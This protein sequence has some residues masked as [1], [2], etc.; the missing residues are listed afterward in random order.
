MA[1]VAFTVAALGASGVSAAAAAT[2]TGSTAATKPVAGSSAKRAA[3]PAAKA[4][5]QKAAAPKAAAPKVRP[6]AFSLPEQPGLAG[7]FVAAGPTRLLDTRKGIGTGGVVAPVGQVPLLLDV[8]QVAGGS[9]TPTSVVLNVTVTN[10]TSGGYVVVYPGSSSR[11]ASSNLDYAAGQTV[12]N[13]VT[14]P[15]GYD[16]KVQF[17]VSGGHADVIADLFGYYTIDKAASTYVP[18]GPSRILDTRS[19]IGTGGVKAPVG[20]G[21]SIRLQ[22]DGV[23]GIPAANVSAVVLNVTETNSSTGGY[24][25]AY[26]DGGSVPTTSNLD[27]PAGKTV[28]NLVTVP[29]GADGKIDFFNKSGTVD[30]IADLAGYYLANAP[31][32]GGILQNLDTPTRLLD[33]R[34]G[35]G[36]GGV[37]APVGAGASISLQVDG[38]AGIA[39][40]NVTA[41]ILNVTE[42]TPSVGGYLTVYPDGGSVPTASNIDF[43]AGETVP[44][45]VVVPVGAD[46]KVDF[47]NKYG[48]TNVIADVFGYFQAGGDLSV[49]TP[50]FTSPTVDTTSGAVAD[51]VTWTVTDSNP[52]ATQTGGELVLR[53]QGSTPNTFVGQWYV[54]DFLSTQ[55]LYQ[56]ATVVSGDAAKATF[57]YDFAVPQYAGAAT[58]K[59]VVALVTVFENATQ[60][61]QLLS[62]S[63]LAGAGNA[64]TATQQVSTVAPSYDLLQL[65]NNGNPPYYYNAGNSEVPYQLEVQDGQSGFWQGTLTISG[66]GGKQ[67]SGSFYYQNDYGVSS[68]MCQGY[69]STANQ[70]TDAHCY[71]YVDIPAGAPAGTWTVSSISLTNN[72]G[73]TKTYTGISALP[74]SVTSDGVISASNFSPSAT[75]LNNWT[76]NAP[77][78]LSMRIAGAQSGVASIQLFW[79][80]FLNVCAQQSTT[81]TAGSGG[82]YTIPV[83][84]YR[85][86]Q[87]LS[88]CTLDGVVITDGAGNVS[89]YGT[90]FGAAATGVKVTTMP[91]TTPPTAS[92]ASLNHTTIAQSQIGNFSYVINVQSSDPTAPV[93]SFS[94]Y[95]YD[96]TGNVVGQEFGGV[97]AGPDGALML[98][99]DVPYGLAVGTYTVGFT[100]TDEAGL[101]T[102][103]GEPGSA[104]VP[105]GPLTFTVTAG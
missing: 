6:H 43:A 80:P 59:W 73:Q 74:I 25:T 30:V 66:P 29:V 51:T 16:G 22:V 56:G 85:T 76:S 26:P 32:S 19:G 103:Y 47:F 97:S 40:K 86:Y 104:P 31:R 95:L 79:G 13:M 69:G 64:V 2:S 44:N 83:V 75:Q 54:V 3:T 36:T 24:L 89:L 78:Q 61:G 65:A 41:V 96:S 53:Q 93:S 4:A 101:S 68:G 42:T 87:A 99:L 62:G 37:K 57:S 60:Q 18:D 77:F 28:A 45:L 20:A 50:K 34:S 55:S 14:V 49:S 105:G 88:T 102:K 15:V 48:T 11:P 21:K 90:E 58:A 12:A 8:S 1:V 98:G 70:S 5:P 38:A 82:V 72:A 100:I 35:L 92:S 91:D 10:Q 94:S 7:K 81:P 46:G 9:A 17:Y 63:E 27:F 67:L 23:A 52:A 84:M 39:Q 33:T 71:V